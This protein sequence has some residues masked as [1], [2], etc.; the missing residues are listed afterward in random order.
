MSKETVTY[1]CGH[2]GE[3]TLRH[4]SGYAAYVKRMKD[5]VLCAKCRAK[6]RSEKRAEKAATTPKA[7]TEVKAKKVA[8]DNKSGE[9]KRRKKAATTS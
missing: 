7:K 4:D 6:A 8:K 5:K 3:R 1:K 9:H 2:T